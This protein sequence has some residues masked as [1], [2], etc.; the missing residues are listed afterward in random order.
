M[1][2]WPPGTPKPTTKD[3][4]S[5]LNAHQQTREYTKANQRG[6]QR[7]GSLAPPL[8]EYMSTSSSLACSQPPRQ[9]MQNDTAHLQIPVWDGHFPSISMACAVGEGVQSH[10]GAASILRTRCNEEQL[11]IPDG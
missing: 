2:A 9:N 4:F 11:A 7:F 10:N 5:S 6:K 8:K 3:T 1:K